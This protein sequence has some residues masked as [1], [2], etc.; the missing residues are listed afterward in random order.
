MPAL[1]D[2][3]V[4]ETNAGHKGSDSRLLLPRCWSSVTHFLTLASSG[5]VYCMARVRGDTFLM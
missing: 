1:A 3:D 2:T 5:N 4:C